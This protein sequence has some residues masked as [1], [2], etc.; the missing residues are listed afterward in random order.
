MGGEKHK[1]GGR[2]SENSQTQ[3]SLLAPGVPSIHSIFICEVFFFT[4]F[5]ISSIISCITNNQV[6]LFYTQLH[7][8]FAGFKASVKE[9]PGKEVAIATINMTISV[10]L[11]KTIVITT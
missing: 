1:M 7:G 4:I 6:G 2:Q 11:T 3:E 8:L 9:G 10:N 5:H